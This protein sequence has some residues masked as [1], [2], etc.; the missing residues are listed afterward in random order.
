MKHLLTIWG[1][2]F[3]T[4]LFVG[5]G[6]Q[7]A[8]KKNFSKNSP[9]SENNSTARSSRNIRG[10]RCHLQQILEVSDSGQKILGIS[11]SESEKKI[12]LIN[13][14]TA[15][16][17]TKLSY[18]TFVKASPNF[19]YFILVDP[20]YRYSVWSIEKNELK[21]KWRLPIFPTDY[22]N[23]EFSP[24][25]R[26]LLVR[27]R[28]SV[29]N[30]K[31]KNQ[32]FDLSTSYLKYEWI[33][34]NTKFSKFSQDGNY[35]LI[36][37]EDVN[38][39]HKKEIVKV[40]IAQQREIFRI[41]VQSPKLATFFD[42]SNDKILLKFHDKIHFHDLA[43]GKLLSSKKIFYVWDIRNHFMLASDGP[44][45]LMFFDLNKLETIFSFPKGLNITSSCRFN[46]S[47]E[48]ICRSDDRPDVYS[49]INLSSQNIRHFCL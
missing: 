37:V 14:E 23:F 9:S 5:C 46:N 27:F 29:Y 6:K 30:K 18:F 22:P 7:S 24:N 35:N 48:V 1:L 38:S 10:E 15:K 19:K 33:E 8:P 2:I 12:E 44:D 3:T 36:L 13:V 4:M 16:V 41:K 20:L 42:V 43:D 32:I 49:L 11:L 21:E 25:E 39:A 47:N 40:D 34:N 26:D 17:I 28:Y 31:S 45:D